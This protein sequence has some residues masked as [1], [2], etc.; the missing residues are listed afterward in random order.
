M[1]DAAR[2]KTMRRPAVV[3]SVR[4]KDWRA[5]VMPRLKYA[6]A[7]RGKNSCA[8][9]GGCRRKPWVSQAKSC[10]GVSSQGIYSGIRKRTGFVSTHVAKHVPQF[11]NDVGSIC[12]KRGP[13][14][15]SAFLALC[16]IWGGVAGGVSSGFPL[17][18]DAA[19]IALREWEVEA[20]KVNP[21]L[22]P[23]EVEVPVCFELKA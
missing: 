15:V 2:R 10:A 18:D 12:M 21:V 8:G 11:F 6:I 14:L 7:P 5:V 17:L 1:E 3:Q 4:G 9:P 19:R 13:Q 22:V 20:A 23:S 16:L